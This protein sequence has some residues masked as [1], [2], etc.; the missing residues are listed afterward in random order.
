MLSRIFLTKSFNLP[1]C[2]VNIELISTSGVF[3]ISL[4]WGV[5]FSKVI[6]D[7]GRRFSLVITGSSII[8]KLGV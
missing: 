7:K 8:P 3:N 6:S 2:L 1:F 4:Y 5:S